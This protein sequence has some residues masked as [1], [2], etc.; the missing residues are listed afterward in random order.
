MKPTDFLVIRSREPGYSVRLGWIEGVPYITDLGSADPVLVNGAPI[1]A[2][3]PC[4][5][6]AGDTITIGDTD[7]TWKPGPTAAQP[8]PEPVEAEPEA[9]PV[10]EPAPAE[11]QPAYQLRVMTADGIS[12]F[13]LQADLVRIGRSRE[14]DLR[15]KDTRVSRNHALLLKHPA[16]YE[17]VDLE[18]AYG[19][20]QD[21]EKIRR[22]VL[23]P[24]DEIWISDETSLMFQAVEPAAQAA[25][26]EEAWSEADT[27]DIPL[28]L[29]QQAEAGEAEPE[30]PPREALRPSE[31]LPTD[32]TMV[33][34]KET[35]APAGER[36]EATFVVRKDRRTERRAEPGETVIVEKTA[37]APAAKEPEARAPTKPPEPEVAGVGRETVW[38]D[39]PVLLATEED[40]DLEA[41][42]PARDT[43]TPHVVVHMRD[44]T[45]EVELTK[46]RLTI[47]R[48]EDSDIPIVDDYVSR[49][50]ASIERQGDQFVIREVRSRNGVWLGRRRID[51]HTLRDGDVLSVGRAKLIFKGGFTRE[52]LTMTD[53]PVIEGKPRRRPVVV[54]PGM[55]GSELWLGSEMLWPN[56]SLVASQVEILSLPGDPRV[57]ARKILDEVVVVPHILRLKKYSALGDYLESGLGYTRGKDLL[58]FAYDW[59]QDVRLAAQRLAEAIDN[60]DV[61]G[62]ISIIAHSLGTLVTRYY[63][64][65]FGGKDVVERIMLMGGPHYGT[66]KGLAAILVGPGMLPFG[67][68]AERMREVLATFPSAY[69]ILPTYPCI[70]GQDGTYIDA[71]KDESWLPEKQRPLLRAGRSFRRELGER[72]SVPTV[73]IFGYGLKTILRV[74]IRRRPDGRWHEVSFVEETAGDVSVPSGSAV[75]K[76]SEIHPV[77]QEHGY[78]FVDD[79]VKMRLK[80]ELTQST[81]K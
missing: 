8:T 30:V 37:H 14:N 39:M 21:D 77:M 45:W 23:R 51:K 63:V 26:L 4:I 10:P 44:R 38:A 18:S 56:L 62:P 53:L 27:I 12:E 48:E 13:P 47:G 64:E 70:V 9:E 2:Y 76:D 58:E 55:M 75:L 19:L 73:S 34:L 1:E 5:I 41:I 22:K 60:W 40:L 3:A 69:Q 15:I 72:S 49:H 81:Q 61:D 59:R 43:R 57:E 79:G 28:E 68:G 6:E 36:P 11:E 54:V 78:L 17:I 7:L 24:G 33:T 67:I 66:P 31:A 29:P 50:H 74:N 35:E 65:F 52:Q 46:E 42:A 16:G 20:L 32:E 25:D 71:L 80:V